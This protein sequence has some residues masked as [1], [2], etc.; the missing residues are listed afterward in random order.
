M[1]EA[2]KY[3][4]KP[5]LAPNQP[6]ELTK[7]T[8]YL[9]WDDA[10]TSG[11]EGWG[12]IDYNAKDEGD[13]NGK[14]Q[15]GSTESWSCCEFQIRIWSDG[16]LTSWA[17]RES[18]VTPQTKK[19]QVLVESG[20]SRGGFINLL[21]PLLQIH[22]PTERLAVK[23]EAP[24]PVSWWNKMVVTNESWN[25]KRA[26]RRNALRWNSGFEN[27]HAGDYEQEV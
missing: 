22:W 16:F 9:S 12:E 18:L 2:E 14:W 24:P 7:L 10:F 26:R 25:P 3:S 27:A 13:K 6:K 15:S 4:D 5:N 8:F 20:T 23:F 21:A 11:A 17:L 1:N 19:C